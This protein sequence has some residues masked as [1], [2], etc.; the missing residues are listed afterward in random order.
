MSVEDVSGSILETAMSLF[1][2]TE[3]VLGHARMLYRSKDPIE[4]EMYDDRVA[5]ASRF[6]DTVEGIVLALERLRDEG[7]VYSSDDAAIESLREEMDE[8]DTELNRY[9]PTRK[10]IMDGMS[11]GEILRSL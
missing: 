9:A 1:H 11:M 2:T 6:F 10:S 7:L 8:L 3:Q 5:Q 4:R